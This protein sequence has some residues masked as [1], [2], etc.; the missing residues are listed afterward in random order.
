MNEAGARRVLATTGGLFPGAEEAAEEWPTDAGA[1]AGSCTC[2]QQACQ[3]WLPEAGQ[4]RKRVA[5]GSKRIAWREQMTSYYAQARG[6]QIDQRKPVMAAGWTT[7]A[8]AHGI[9]A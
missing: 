6:G 2:T 4:Y 7:T 5:G 3:G 1:A 9:C 8:V